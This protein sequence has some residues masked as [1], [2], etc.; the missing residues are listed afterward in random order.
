MNA[1]FLIKQADANNHHGVMYY[2]NRRKELGLPPK[3]YSYQ[4][5]IAFNR[6]MKKAS[7]N[8][9]RTYGGYNY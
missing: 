9:K 5:R 1:L 4:Q 3:Y 7:R 2:H 6:Q 8:Y